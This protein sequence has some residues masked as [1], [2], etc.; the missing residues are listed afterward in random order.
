METCAGAPHTVRGQGAG[1]GSIDPIYLRRALGPALPKI[2][3]IASFLQM[4]PQSD[5][6]CLGSGAV[7]AITWST[8]GSVNIE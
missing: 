7:W 2:F 1:S 6:S 3:L 4:S 5:F 8:V